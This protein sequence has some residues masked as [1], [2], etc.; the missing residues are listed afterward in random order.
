LADTAIFEAALMH[1]GFG[2]HE[3]CGIFIVVGD[4]GIDV[5]P[6][7]L[8]RGEGRALERFAVQDR[9]PD[10]DLTESGSAR[11]REV[12]MHVGML[13]EPTVVLG[14][15]GTEIV[16]DGVQ[17]VAGIGGDDL[18]HEGEE[19][20]PPPAA[21]VGGDHLAGDHIQRREERGCAVPLVIMALTGER[22]AVGQ[23]QIA[24]RPFQGLDRRLFVNADDDRVLGRR[25]I[26]PDDV[27]SLGSK[28]GIVAFAPGFAPR[29][30]N[31]VSTQEPPDILDIDVAECLGQERP[32]PAAIA[33]RRRL[34]Q[35]RPE[36]VC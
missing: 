2:P 24:L 6:E 22:S 31:L 8:D 4:E 3:G 14:L 12:E 29:E 7:L 5:I 15:M 19:L 32:T 30:V 20:D 10:F 9:E 16:N 17:F 33:L 34:I 13:L 18:V 25:Q 26:E 21:L 1:L 27:G 35:K 36:C 11:R 23:L 28:L